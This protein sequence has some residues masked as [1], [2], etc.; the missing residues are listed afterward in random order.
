MNIVLLVAAIIVAFLVLAWM[1]KV[2]KATIGTAILVAVIV[3][4]LQL[5]FG[6][7]PG[8]LWQQISQFPQ[9]IWQ[10]FNGQ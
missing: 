1:L 3:L 2:A 4:V 8:Q 7:G 9:A 5:V 10:T 6:I